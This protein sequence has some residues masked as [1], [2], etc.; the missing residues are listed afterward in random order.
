MNTTKKILLLILVNSF[1][2]INY[3]PNIGIYIGLFA[4]VLI[5]ISY[6]ITIF[7]ALLLFK[8]R[9]E[10]IVFI[11]L[12]VFFHLISLLPLFTNYSSFYFNIDLADKGYYPSSF[13]TLISTIMIYFIINIPCNSYLL[14]KLLHTKF[15]K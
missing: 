3:L 12:I 9:C 13:E 4:L 15:V 2:T 14:T 8:K 6:L 10:F 1:W 11:T 5:P 7:L